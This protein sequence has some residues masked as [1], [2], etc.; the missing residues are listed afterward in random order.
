MWK[1]SHYELLEEQSAAKVISSG[2][3][4]L[5]SVSMDG[6]V[7]CLNSG[8]RSFPTQICSANVDA[9]FVLTQERTSV[10]G[11]GYFDQTMRQ[12]LKLHKMFPLILVC[13]G[14]Y[15]LGWQHIFVFLVEL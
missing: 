12:T 4:S 3:L 7:I 1:E 5:F 2:V 14:Q 13:V 11:V 9:D 8:W 15:R 10:D 6:H